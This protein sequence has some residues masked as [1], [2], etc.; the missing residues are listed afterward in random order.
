MAIFLYLQKYVPGSV[1]MFP[2]Y[3]EIDAMYP[4]QKSYF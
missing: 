3:E 4:K 1:N 2:Q